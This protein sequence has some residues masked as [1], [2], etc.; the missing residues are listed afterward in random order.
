MHGI[1]VT[2]QSVR[3]RFR[4]GLAHVPEDR[5]V[6]A[7][8]PALSLREN[9][10]LKDYASPAFARAGLIRWGRVTAHA[11]ERLTCFDVRGGTP[12]SQAGLLSGG[13]QQKLVLAREFHI[14]V[15]AP[16][17][18]AGSQR[19]HPSRIIVAHN[20][21]RGLDVA[22][23]RFVFQQLLDQRDAGAAI[24]LIHSDL[25]ELLEL[26]DRVMVMFRGRCLPTD[27]P[28]CDRTAIGRMMMVG[29]ARHEAQPMLQETASR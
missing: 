28:A 1:D 24:L 19:V 23:T 16:S 2:R 18:Q 13:N 6:Q 9:L 5:L 17:S 21:V 4:T 20:P 12:G 15:E 26:S 27:W 22:A 25:D 8:V 29:E 3:A 10:I 14:P 11:A 7:L